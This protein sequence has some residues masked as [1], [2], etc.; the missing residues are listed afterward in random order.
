MADKIEVEV[1]GRSKYE[2][3]HLMAMNVL[4]DCEKKQLSAITRKDYFNAV[5]DAIDALAGVRVK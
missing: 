3:A 5:A 4:R 1:T 2:I